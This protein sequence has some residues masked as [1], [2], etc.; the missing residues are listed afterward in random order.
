MAAPPSRARGSSPAARA[1][2]GSDPAAAPGG[3]AASAGQPSRPLPP[4][5]RPLLLRPGLLLAPAMA[6]GRP[7]T[8]CLPAGYVAVPPRRAARVLFSWR[9]P[10]G[11]GLARNN[12]PQHAQ[13]PPC[14][15]PAP[16]ATWRHRGPASTASA[17]DF[18]LRRSHESRLRETLGQRHAPPR[19]SQCPK[20]PRERRTG[21]AGGKKEQARPGSHAARPSLNKSPRPSPWQARRRPQGALPASAPRGPS[22]RATAFVL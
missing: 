2:P 14:P 18:A 17:G 12:Q 15:G 3:A 1:E 21:S 13:P 11:R 6:G 4:R 16:Q 20:P 7:F 9:L 22:P 10:H 19:P 8:N 5:P